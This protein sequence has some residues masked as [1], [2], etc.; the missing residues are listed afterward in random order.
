MPPVLLRLPLSIAV[1]VCFASVC[2]IPLHLPVLRVTPVPF[3]FLYFFASRCPRPLVSVFSFVS[4]W[5]AGVG[6]FG[7]CVR[8]RL[9]RA[10]LFSALGGRQVLWLV[11][12]CRLLFGSLLKSC[13][14]PGST[15][16]PHDD[17]VC[18]VLWIDHIADGVAY[19][20]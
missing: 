4:A 17:C 3:V 12:R 6:G 20:P 9:R 8:A 13:C 5:R 1:I 19:V 14:R 2:R 7:N 18:A 11:L 15:L 10:L 16:I